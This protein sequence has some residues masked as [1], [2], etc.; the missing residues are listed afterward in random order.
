MKTTALTSARIFEKFEL[1]AELQAIERAVAH[2]IFERRS[3]LRKLTKL[4]DYTTMN[5]CSFREEQINKMLN[6]N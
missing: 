6:E 5:R 1:S 4:K 3:H 2:L